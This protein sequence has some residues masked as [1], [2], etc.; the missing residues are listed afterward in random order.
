MDLKTSVVSS[1]CF[2]FLLLTNHCR[3]VKS[4][5]QLENEF[6]VVDNKKAANG[7]ILRSIDN[8]SRMKCA[9]ACGREKKSGGCSL[10]NYNG[11]SKKCELT[12]DTLQNAVDDPMAK[13][14]TIVPISGKALGKTHLIINI[15]IIYLKNESVYLVI[16]YR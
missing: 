12:A 4:A 6:T 7:V 8:I 10:A 2:V 11:D 3:L 9:M 16:M 5:Q 14:K 15:C 13:W 1:Y